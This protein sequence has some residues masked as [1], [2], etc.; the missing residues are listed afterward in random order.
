MT[1]EEFDQKS[2]GVLFRIEEILNDTVSRHADIERNIVGD[3]GFYVG[4]AYYYTN[5]F[6][7]EIRAVLFPEKENAE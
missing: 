4:K 3:V 2:R 7:Q 6:L 1:K 5:D